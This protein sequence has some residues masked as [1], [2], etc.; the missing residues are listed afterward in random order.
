MDTCGCMVFGS[1]PMWLWIGGMAARIFESM[2]AQE[3]E[4]Y[5]DS[6]DLSPKTG[7]PGVLGR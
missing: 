6:R 2:E 1:G 7:I 5:L 3:V 4:V